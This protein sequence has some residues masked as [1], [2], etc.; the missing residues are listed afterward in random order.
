[1]KND[2]IKPSPAAIKKLK[3]KKDRPLAT[4]KFI[5]LYDEEKFIVGFRML[6]GG[7]M[8]LPEEEFDF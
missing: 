2:L 8:E 3:Q 6:Q 1:M 5:H 7:E 4:D